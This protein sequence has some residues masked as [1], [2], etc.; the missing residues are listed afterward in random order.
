MAA[1]HT[2]IKLGCRGLV[3]RAKTLEVHHLIVCPDI[4]LAPN[5]NSS[6]CTLTSEPKAEPRKWLLV[7]FLPTDKTPMKERDYVMSPMKWMFFPHSSYETQG[8][9]RQYKQS[10]KE[11]D[12]LRGDTY[13]VTAL[14]PGK[15]WHFLTTVSSGP[16]SCTLMHNGH[17]RACVYMYVETTQRRPAYFSV[18]G[19]VAGLAK[20][21][22]VNVF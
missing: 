19:L 15:C 20:S 1:G 17:V 12:W 2:V 4:Y 3:E 22:T 16:V 11:E 21:Q 14:L 10:T 6:N 5:Y 8:K 7:L 18:W 9:C 13:E